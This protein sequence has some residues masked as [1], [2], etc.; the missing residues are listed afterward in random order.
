MSSH[1]MA[2]LFIAIKEPFYHNL[3]LYIVAPNAFNRYIWYILKN[4]NN[5]HPSPLYLAA[6]SFSSLFV[7]SNSRL[8]HLKQKNF[9]VF[10]P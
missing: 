7:I 4:Q 5:E 10:L 1:A 8:K 6:L 3:S 2:T 9:L